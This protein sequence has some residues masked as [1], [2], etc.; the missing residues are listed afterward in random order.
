MA[1]IGGRRPEP[2]DAGGFAQGLRRSQRGAAGNGDQGG[3]ELLGLCLDLGL[4]SVDLDGQLTASLGDRGA[5]AGDDA[6]QTGEAL[7]DPI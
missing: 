1:G 4:K 2:E 7:A 5:E 6:G 3:R